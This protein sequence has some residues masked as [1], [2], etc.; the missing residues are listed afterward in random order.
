M[1]SLWS[2]QRRGAECTCRRRTAHTPEFRHCRVHSLATRRCARESCSQRGAVLMRTR[3][4]AKAGCRMEIFSHLASPRLVAAGARETR[5]WIT[6]VCKCAYN[7][8][9][10]VLTLCMFACTSM[11]GSPLALN[12]SAASLILNFE[13]SSA[14]CREI[15]T[16]KVSSHLVPQNH[17]EIFLFARLSLISVFHSF[18]MSY[19]N[20]LST[21]NPKKTHWR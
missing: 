8:T 14:T 4:F 1:K 20:L 12:F 10:P 2:R 5:A 16:W 6:A 17:H 19:L 7:C 15:L 13:K 9:H 3:S 18:K 11:Q 21:K